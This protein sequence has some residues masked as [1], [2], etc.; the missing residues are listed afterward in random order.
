METEKLKEPITVII[1]KSS[2]S[3]LPLL[4]LPYMMG[5]R[6]TDLKLGEKSLGGENRVKDSF[7][8]AIGHQAKGYHEAP[9]QRGRTLIKIKVIGRNELCSCG[10]GK[11][12]KKCC[13]LKIG[14]Q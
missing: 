11:K 1:G 12:Y 14:E 6:L 8:G 13:L 3:L 4:L 9:N 5:V 2:K 10:S 7:G